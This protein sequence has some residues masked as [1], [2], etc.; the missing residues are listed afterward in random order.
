MIWASAMTAP[1]MPEYG[2]A[3]RSDRSG[4]TFPRGSRPVRGPSLAAA[5]LVA[6]IGVSAARRP[7]GRRS[8]V[9]VRR[10][11]RRRRARSPPANSP[12]C[13][14][15][16]AAAR[17]A[18]PGARPRSSSAS[19]SSPPGWLPLA[20]LVGAGGAWL[21]I[22]WL[23]DQRSIADI[24]HLAASLSLGAAGAAAGR[25]AGDRRRRRCTPPGR[26]SALVAGRVHLPGRHA[27]AGR[28][29]ADPAPG[30]TA[31]RR[32]SVRALHA[33][34]PMFVGNVLIGLFALF[35]LVRE[36]LWLLAFPPALWLL[37]RTYRY[38]L[39]AEE[40]RRIW[41]AFA[42]AT[43]DLPGA[44][45]ARRGA[46]PGCAARWTSSAHAGWRSRSTRRAAASAGT[47][48]D[49]PGQDIAAAGLPGPAITRT[50]AV[51]GDAGR[52]A[53]RLAGRAD[54]AGDPRRT[55]GV[56]VRGRARRRAARRGRARAAGRARGAGGAGDDVTDPL[57]GLANR[58]ALVADGDRDAARSRPRPARRACC[59][60]T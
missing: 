13:A 11:R 14:S 36:P 42:T 34:V 7:A 31:P 21:L 2:S 32:S 50:M 40:E 44:D 24:V 10:G 53:D 39:R 37:Q 45:G 17:S 41:E 22:S 43:A 38:H 4:R 15:G 48:E 29:D 57:T 1:P 49:A 23:S 18:S 54:A 19:R 55:G 58:S 56:R 28:A 33:K 16:S 60:S 27:R 52:R 20:T 35:V 8:T 3:A 30:R 51:G 9:G 47:T 25:P 26:R 6:V 59:C 46:T 12:G 5:V